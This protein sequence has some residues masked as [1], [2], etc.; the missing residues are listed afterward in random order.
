MPVAKK[1]PA[2]GKALK[3]KQ[4]TQPTPQG[5]RVVPRITSTMKAEA[6]KKACLR[7]GE[8]KRAKNV[9]VCLF[10]SVKWEDPFVVF[11]ACNRSQGGRSYKFGCG[12]SRVAGFLSH[13]ERNLFS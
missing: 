1:G 3:V 10:G 7:R 6:N 4:E 2:K 8:G 9:K 11:G 13:W 12:F 5:R